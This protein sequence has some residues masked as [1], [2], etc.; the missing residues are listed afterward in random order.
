MSARIVLYT[1]AGCHLCEIAKGKLE[2][3]RLSC[4]FDLE[5]VDIETEPALLERYGARIPVV[6]VDGRPAFEHRVVLSDL[7]RIL[8]ASSARYETDRDGPDP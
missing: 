4:D 5:E 7:L 2:R 6:T 8:G 3:A 1:K